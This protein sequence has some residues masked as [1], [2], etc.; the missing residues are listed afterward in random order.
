MNKHIEV[1]KKWLA[2]KESVTKEELEA[3]VDAAYAAANA[4]YAADAADAAA[5]DATY[6]PNAASA[7]FAAADAANAADCAKRLVNKYEEL[8]K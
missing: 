4:A 2:D 6:A 1:V 3:N 8:T 7:A 5:Y